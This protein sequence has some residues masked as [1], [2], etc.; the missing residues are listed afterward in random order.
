MNRLTFGIIGLML[1]PVLIVGFIVFTTAWIYVPP[2]SWG[3]IFSHWI[4]LVLISIV[5]I[6]CIFTALALSHNITRQIT[7][8]TNAARTMN[9]GK[10]VHHINIQHLYQEFQP[11][12]WYI[13]SHK[14]FHDELTKNLEDVLRGTRSKTL[15]LRSDDDDF[16][17]LLNMLIVHLQNMYQMTRAVT[18]GNLA[19]LKSLDEP[20]MEPEKQTYTMISQLGE[21]ISKARKSTNQII[22]AGSQI[23]SITTQGLQDTKAATKRVND[24]SQSIHQMAINIQQVAEH[25]QEQ[26]SLLDDTSSSIDQTMR[27]IEEIASSVTYLKSIIENNPSSSLASEDKGPSSQGSC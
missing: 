13:N 2:E 17:K 27:S 7:L 19:I 11:L 10:T 6:G 18:E 9:F 20:G 21:L 16:I 12:Y 25:L 14:E 5:F 23:N 1:I 8:I 3:K 4:T 26:S 15:E 22:H 24:I